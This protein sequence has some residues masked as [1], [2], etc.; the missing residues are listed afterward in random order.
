M[1]VYGFSMPET[2]VN[3][4]Y[5]LHRMM[6]RRRDNIHVEIIDPSSQSASRFW[7]IIQPV[8]MSHV[9]NVSDMLER[10][11]SVS[12]EEDKRFMTIIEQASLPGTE[13]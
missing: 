1:V 12:S 6:G 11:V 8:S 3:F 9:A 2:D 10:R 7:D 5:L 13:E 4:R